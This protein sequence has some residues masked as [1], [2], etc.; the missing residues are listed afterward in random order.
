MDNRPRYL[1]RRPAINGL[2][3][4]LR[5]LT[6]IR[7]IGAYPD[8]MRYFG[9]GGL[10]EARRLCAAV[11]R[12]PEGYFMPDP[13]ASFRNLDST[14]TV[15]RGRLQIQDHYFDSPAPSGRPA[16]DRV[17]VRL[18]SHDRSGDRERVVVFHHPIY[19]AKWRA[20][21]WFLEPLIRQV[22]VAF[23][24]A[25]NHYGRR[26]PDEFPGE[27]SVNSNPYTLIQ[28]IRQWCWD[29]Q[30]TSNLLRNSIG[31]APAA[32]A[33]FSVGGFQ[34]TLLAALGGLDL[35]LITLATTSRYAYGI[36]HGVIG[37]PILRA[38]S[39]AGIS[40]GTLEE[41]ADV[42]QVERYAHKLR[43]R[44]VLMIRGLF[45]KVDPPPSMERLEAALRPSRVLRLP[46]G[47]GTMMFHRRAVM[48]EIILFLSDLGII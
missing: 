43:G 1:F 32:V 12:D 27:W 15:R 41:M 25:P 10:A 30:A 4:C 21:E 48:D 2:E 34:T 20:W 42:L 29:Q 19:Q 45:D 47:H 35:P 24:A 23:M 9:A 3:T 46:T 31:L 40:P 5:V 18:Y 16:N 6:R 8:P 14:P 44:E 39:R 7:G 22:P 26:A 36:I 38:M 33:G 13:D 37:R 17:Q 28:A 11:S